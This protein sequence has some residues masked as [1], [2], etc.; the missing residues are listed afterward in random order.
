MGRNFLCALIPLSASI[1][2]LKI[3]R[4]SLSLLHVNGMFSLASRWDSEN[5]MSGMKK[6]EEAGVKFIRFFIS[7]RIIPILSVGENSAED[8][9]EN[10]ETGWVRRDISFL[11]LWALNFPLSSTS[12][13]I[14]P[15]IPMHKTGREKERKIPLSGEVRMVTWSQHVLYIHVHRCYVCTIF[16]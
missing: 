11:L 14:R 7:C 6:V 10:L 5:P 15:W 9:R 2:N 12:V 16:M 1:S 4:L 13:E 3:R 8:G